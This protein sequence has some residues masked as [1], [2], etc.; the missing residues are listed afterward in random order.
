MGD[1]NPLAV[2]YEPEWWDRSTFP[3]EHDYMRIGNVSF[4]FN[5]VYLAEN[6]LRRNVIAC[7]NASPRGPFNTLSSHCKSAAHSVK[8]I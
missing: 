2:G 4:P 8:I 1:H 7:N 6:Q 3:H 5:L